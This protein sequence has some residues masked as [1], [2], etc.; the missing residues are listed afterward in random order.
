VIY[1]SYSAIERNPLFGAVFIWVLLAIKANQK[2]L[3]E[4]T[5]FIDVLLP[6][7]VISDLS[8][9]AYSYWEYRT[10]TITH[11]LFY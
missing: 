11:G 9:A 10:G 2:D 4:L 5:D 3:T 6:A 7:H 8:I 1:N